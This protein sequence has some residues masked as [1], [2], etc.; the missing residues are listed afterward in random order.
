MCLAIPGKVVDIEGSEPAFLR[1]RVDFSGIRREISFAYVPDVKPG[2]YVLVHVG[3][4]LEI[5]DEQEAK[6]S[7]QTLDEIFRELEGS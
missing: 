7:L 1:G 5:I 3:F 2:D 6:R 4:A